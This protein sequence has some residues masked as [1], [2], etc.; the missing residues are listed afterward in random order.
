[1]FVKLFPSDRFACL[2]SF[3]GITFICLVSLFNCFLNFSFLTLLAALLKVFLLISTYAISGAA[4]S[5][6]PHFLQ[7]GSST[8]A[9]TEFWF[10]QKFV[11]VHRILFHAADHYLITSKIWNFQLSQSNHLVTSLSLNLNNGTF[12]IQQF[13]SSNTHRH[14]WYSLNNC[15]CQVFVN[16]MK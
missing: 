14:K 9:K 8:F 3:V 6:Q 1:M 2:V 10:S 7:P 5:I 11:Q 16:K 12:P 13:K 4:V 15:V